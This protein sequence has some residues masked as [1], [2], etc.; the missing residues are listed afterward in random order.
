MASRIPHLIAIFY[1]WATRG[2]LSAMAPLYFIE[3]LYAFSIQIL[4]MI[5]NNYLKRPLNETLH[6]SLA[7]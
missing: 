3:C 1:L 7:F 5:A 2:R 6:P 4:F